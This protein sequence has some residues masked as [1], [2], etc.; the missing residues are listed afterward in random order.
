MPLDDGRRGLEVDRAAVA[1]R[2]RRERRR[3]HLP[4]GG[5][6]LAKRSS[7]PEGLEHRVPGSGDDLLVAEE[8]PQ[9][10]LEHYEPRVRDNERRATNDQPL[11]GGPFTRDAS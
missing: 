2:Q 1:G 9:P 11:R 4:A 3:V 8:R 10:A 7:R 6:E 5:S